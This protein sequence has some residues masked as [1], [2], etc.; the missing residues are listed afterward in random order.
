MALAEGPGFG[1]ASGAQGED[2]ELIPIVVDDGGEALAEAGEE[3]IVEVGDEDAFLDAGAEVE[4]KRGKAAAAAIIVYVVA[5]NVLHWGGSVWFGEIAS[6]EGGRLAA[7]EAACSTFALA[8]GWRSSG[9]PIF[10]AGE[11]GCSIW[12]RHGAKRAL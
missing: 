5:D 12:K 9:W 10:A 11:T 8:T 6:L 3:F 7:G 1:F 4:E 2:V